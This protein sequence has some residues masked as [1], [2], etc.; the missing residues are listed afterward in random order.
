M[1]DVL[2]KAEKHNSHAV[3]RRQVSVIWQKEPVETSECA[4]AR[5]C[6]KEEQ[7]KEVVGERLMAGQRRIE[8]KHLWSHIFHDAGCLKYN[9]A[10]TNQARSTNREELNW[11]RRLS[12]KEKQP[13]FIF[14]SSSLHN[15]CIIIHWA[16]QPSHKHIPFNSTGF[17]Y[18]F[19]NLFIYFCDMIQC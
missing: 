1:T 12:W 10:V 11:G 15:S 5:T 4:L 16:C 17:I 8:R 14:R 7:A 9:S 13:W 3:Y 2:H 19:I 6:C 18:I